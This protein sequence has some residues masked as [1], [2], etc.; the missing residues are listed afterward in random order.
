[1]AGPKPGG[2]ALC[3]VLAPTRELAKQASCCAFG[4]QLVWC[5]TR[6]SEDGWSVGSAVCWPPPTRE[7]VKQ[8]PFQPAAWLLK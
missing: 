4:Q 1:M 7:L 2:K 8:V 5:G 6:D 3:L